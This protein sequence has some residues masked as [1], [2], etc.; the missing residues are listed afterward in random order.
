MQPDKQQA[1]V[2]LT[3]NAEASPETVVTRLGARDATSLNTITV[4]AEQLDAYRGV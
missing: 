4:S 2:L 1:Y 3:S